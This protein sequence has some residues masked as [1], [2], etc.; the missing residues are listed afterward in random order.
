MD[1]RYM[2]LGYVSEQNNPVVKSNTKESRENIR[3]SS[4]RSSQHGLVLH[5]STVIDENLI[6]KS[7]LVHNGRTFSEIRINSDMIGFRVGEFSTTA[8]WYQPK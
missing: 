2:L 3:N 7:V 1:W 6:G 4:S 8:T 5:R